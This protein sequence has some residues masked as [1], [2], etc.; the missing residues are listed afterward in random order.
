MKENNLGLIHIICGDGKG[1]TT[2]AIGLSVRAAGRNHKVLIARFLKSNDSGELN[3]L[4][5][6]EQITVLP[7]TKFF[8]FTWQ[9]NEEQK[10]E[11]KEYYNDTLK[12]AI[13]LASK[14]EY[15][16]LILDEILSVYNYDFVE[17]SVL[18]DFLKNKP[19]EL[20]VVMTGRNPQEELCELADY[21]SEVKKVKHPYEQGVP[22][23]IGIE[24]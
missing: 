12:E 1:K 9:M 19:K 16:L 17:H 24:Y 6:I 22:A 2:A 4:E 20:E 8:G 3:T 15:D 10:L 7:V 18:I 13:S 11:A 14:G 23:R 5:K 21:I